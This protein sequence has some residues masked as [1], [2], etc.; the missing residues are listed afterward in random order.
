MAAP[1]TSRQDQAR[2]SAKM[3]RINPPEREMSAD[4]DRGVRREKQKRAKE[5]KRQAKQQQQAAYAGKPSP[6][7][8]AAKAA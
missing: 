5:L 2:E 6:A 1:G 4:K 7:A 8:K 3:P